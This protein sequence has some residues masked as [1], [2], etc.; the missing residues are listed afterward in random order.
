MSD[1]RAV[2]TMS[3]VAEVSTVLLTVT[4]WSCRNNANIDAVEHVKLIRLITVHAVLFGLT[5]DAKGNDHC[6]SVSVYERS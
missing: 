3:T 4:T 2:S 5:S 6:Q 1:H